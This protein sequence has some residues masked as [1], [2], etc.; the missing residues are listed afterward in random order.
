MRHLFFGEDDAIGDWAASRLGMVHGFL[1][2]YTSIGAIENGRLTGAAVFNVYSGD[3]VELTIVGRGIMNRAAFRV[4]A[5]YVFTTLG[6][7]RLSVTTRASN[8]RVIGMAERL[9]FVEEG[10]R[11][12]R[13]GD[14]DGIEF[15]MLKEECRWLT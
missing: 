15:G 8:Y 12:C 3:D 6:C 14:E 13:Y 2:P 7:R 9:G 1:R 11:R 5:G 4:I 10:R